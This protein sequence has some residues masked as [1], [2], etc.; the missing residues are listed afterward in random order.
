MSSEQLRQ[1]A[2]KNTAASSKRKTKKSNGSFRLFGM[3]L[4]VGGGFDIVFMVLVFMLLTIGLVMMFSASYISAKYDASTGYD[5]TYYI[6]RQ[7]GFAL[8]GIAMMF[9]VSKINPEIFKKLTPV[10]AA[11]SVVLL[12]L[13]LIH[14]YR[15]D[16]KE[17]FRRWLNLGIVF[18]PSDIAKLGIIML[19]AW[20]LEKY[21][22]MIE[23][24]WWVS[25]C[26]FMLL[27]FFCGLIVME[28][29]LSCTIL[30]FGIG[31]GMLYLGGVDKRWFI[32]G[33]VVGAALVTA[34]IL[35]RHK[36]LEPYQAER[37]DSFFYK[38]YDDTNKRWQTNQSLFALGS[39]GFFGLGLGNSRQKYLYMPEPQND[40]IF[41]IVGEELGFFRCVLI[42]LL[43][44][45][46]VFRGFI[47]ASRSKGMYERMVVLGISLQV[48][49]QTILNILVVTD[50]APN[51]G[52]SLPFFSYGGTALI[53]QLIE[54]GMVL[55]V[56]R[57]G[58]RK[59]RAEKDA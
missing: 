8:I 43:F 26:L 37:I 22:H 56:S 13:V 10:I 45:A 15:L 32:I 28:K 47:I 19:F 52:I 40:F 21:R 17:D 53:M 20:L 1:T 49:L 6:K 16:G 51:T 34:F 42:I 36:I 41:A 33:I 48:G 2:G 50:L 7:L 54:M 12:V 57:S 29:H 23:T 39:G 55:G 25:L 27:A 18:Q 24:K 5:A 35:L 46:L 59:K 14:P 4:F 44:A 11:I 58:D 30:V 9:V 31:I 3:D 38:D